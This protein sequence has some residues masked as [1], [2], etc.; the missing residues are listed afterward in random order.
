MLIFNVFYLFSC[1]IL[2]RRIELGAKEY[3]E[4]IG[5]PNS[6]SPTNANAF[7]YALYSEEM[8]DA[9]E[10]IGAEMV[11]SNVRWMFPIGLILNISMF[12]WV[13]SVAKYR[14]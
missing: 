8:T 14:G 10:T 9:C 1:R 7:L 6:F 12:F 2:M 5:R 13:A 3:W 4:S 11:L